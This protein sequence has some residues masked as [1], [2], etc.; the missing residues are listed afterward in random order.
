MQGSQ[1]SPVPERAID[2]LERLRSE[3][4]GQD[5]VPMPMAKGTGHLLVDHNLI[6]E[7]MTSRKFIRPEFLRKAFGEGLLF[8]EG[9]R[10]KISRRALKPDMSVSCIRSR[11]PLVAGHVEDLVEEWTAEARAGREIEVVKDIAG[12]VFRASVS[13][14]FGVDLGAHDPR[15]LSVIR[16]SAASNQLSGLGVFDPRRTIDPM[17]TSVLRDER[18]VIASLGMEFVERRRNE[19]AS[20]GEP[21]LLD[22]LLDASFIDAETENGCPVGKKGLID[23]LVLLFLASTETTTASSANTIEF[24]SRNPETLQRLREELDASGP[25]SELEYTHCCFH[26]AL[27]LRPPVWFNGRVALEEVELSNGHVIEEGGFVFIC[28]YL[29]HHDP[30]LWEDSSEFRPERFMDSKARQSELF[31]PFGLGHHYCIGAGMATLIG[32]QLVAG[33][34]KLLDV[35]MLSRPTDEPLDGFLLG[36]AM[37]SKAALVIRA[38]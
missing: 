24:L 6:R 26:E 34:C 5:V 9:E 27:R 18:E 22:R 13:S 4:M 25:D 37:G 15:A 29:V 21:D 35:D 14:F 11:R 8:A 30:E 17:M 10:W 1:S 7:V 28:P 38:V 20:S 31:M 33:I 2:L 3:S 16:L 19:P 32:T 23:E 36:P 12:T